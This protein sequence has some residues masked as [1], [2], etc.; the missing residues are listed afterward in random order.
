MA[1][2]LEKKATFNEVAE[3]Y[4]RVRNRYPGQLFDDL[5]EAVQLN[6]QSRI[7]EIGPGTGIAT[8]ELAKRGCRITAVELGAEMAAVAKRNL[9]DFPNVDM[10]VGA[11]EQWEPP[12]SVSFDLVI[13][14]TAF[15]WLDPEVRFAKPAALLRPG[16]HLAIVNYLHAAGGDRL[17]FEQV[18]SFYESYMPGTPPNLRLTEVSDMKPD[19]GPFENS[20]LFE[21]PTVRHYVTEE[22]YSTE[23]YLDLLSTYSTHLTLD[24]D[25]RQKL[26]AC[27]GSLIDD[28]FGGSVTKCYLNELMLARKRG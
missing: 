4:D 7:L 25:N 26:F 27:I 3:L 18:Q 9:A 1:L 22:T 12:A 20:G 8:L 2:P 14:A 13:A 23:Q 5:F 16:G 17:F 28:Q 10:H 15:H 21:K 24:A 6:P 19:T 11:F